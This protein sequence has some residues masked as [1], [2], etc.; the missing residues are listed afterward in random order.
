LDVKNKAITIPDL[1]H[2]NNYPGFYVIGFKRLTDIANFCISGN[3]EV[4]FR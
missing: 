3:V 1:R 4:H 2:R